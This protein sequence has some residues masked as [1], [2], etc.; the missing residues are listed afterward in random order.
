MPQAKAFDEDVF[1]GLPMPDVLPSINS[2]L[3]DDGNKGDKRYNKTFTFSMND[4][5]WQ[6]LQDVACHPN[7][8]FDGVLAACVRH[9]LGVT[10]EQLQGHISEERR[11]L[12][13]VMMDQQR[14]LT[15]ERIIV[16]IDQLIDTQVEHLRFWTGKADWRMV[17]KDLRKFLEEVKAYPEPAWREH[18]AQ[19]WMRHQGVRSL[20]KFWEERMK[21]DSIEE[22]RAT[23][24][25]DVE[26]AEMAGE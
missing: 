21:E 1:R 10:L 19:I 15:R 14:R 24:A 11:T 25:I 16:T 22:W 5:M 23:A 3:W 17:V 12:F 7:M 26:W 18:T 20:R 6:T 9:A 4:V 2:L 8:P 13:R